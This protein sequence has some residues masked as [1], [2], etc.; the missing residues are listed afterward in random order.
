MI[1]R[2]YKVVETESIVTLERIVSEYIERGYKA[3]GGV[4]VIATSDRDGGMTYYYN[5]AVVKC[6]LRVFGFSIALK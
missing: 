6:A 4:S 5:Q 3:Q 2:S 1:D